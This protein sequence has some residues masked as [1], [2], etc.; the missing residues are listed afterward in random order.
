MCGDKVASVGSSWKYVLILVQKPYGVALFS[1]GAWAVVKCAHWA[2]F[3]LKRKHAE[4]CEGKHGRR[5]IANSVHT[6][7]HRASLHTSHGR[8]QLI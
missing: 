8:V 3:K 1:P 6:V 4:N 5:E 7:L 2:L